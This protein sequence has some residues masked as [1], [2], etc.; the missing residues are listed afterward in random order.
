MLWDSSLVDN[1]NSII[2]AG[3]RT[4]SKKEVQD[5]LNAGQRHKAPGYDVWA[6]RQRKRYEGDQEQIVREA[7][8]ARYPQTFQRMPIIPINWLQMIAASDAGVYNTAPDRYL[9]DEASEKI[10]DEKRAAELEWLVDAADLDGILPELE[11]RTLALGT[12]FGVVDWD[13]VADE[14][15][16]SL[17][18]PSD[19]V[20]ICDN[21][22]PN[23]IR[24][25]LVFGHKTTSPNGIADPV[26]WWRIFSRES[27]ESDTWW[28]H[29]VSEN[30]DAFYVGGDPATEYAG[31]L[32]V[33]VAHAGIPSGSVYLDADRDIAS[34]VDG[35][36]VSRSNLQYIS[37][38]QGHGQPYYS[39]DSLE[40]KDITIGP[41]HWNK[42]ATN[43]RF[44]VLNFNAEF[45]EIREGNK[46]ALRELAISRSNNPD[47][48]A[49]EP[50]PP[51]SGIARQVQNQ[52]HDRK[53]QR[54]SH[55]FVRMEEQLLWPILLD[56][57]DNVSSRPIKFGAL[58]VCVTPKSAVSYE[59]QTDKM[60]RLEAGLDRKVLS[61][62]QYA[63]AAFP[64]IYPTVADA[65]AVGI[66]DK[67]G[68]GT[69]LAAP[70]TKF[71]G[72]TLA[73]KTD[74]PSPDAKAS[75][76]AVNNGE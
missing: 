9:E 67:I 34:V 15:R 37:D 76:P 49:T 29:I 20:C 45:A 71:G 2:A 52:Q 64:D 72:L 57:H 44:D 8:A 14:P 50:G 32:P 7:M 63:S 13:T 19:T 3:H 66:S 36:N 31:L 16:I 75:A 4:F 73:S 17:H 38:L 69:Q 22:A 30:G 25:A 21:S 74:A 47:A 12:I 54:L 6:K 23:D 68:Q 5:I 60:A 18:Y 11:Q 41:D 61:P 26:S 53:V 51:E 24:K 46:L 62:A 42:I 39:G 59:I 1:L 28:V 56:M 58:T 55:N 65:V 48:Y 43:E 33:F 27:V 40:M 35:L 10:E 70:A